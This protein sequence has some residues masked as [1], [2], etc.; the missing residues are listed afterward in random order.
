[1]ARL[2]INM[3]RIK[4]GHI[5]YINSYPIFYTILKERKNLPFDLVSD[6]PTRLNALMRKGDLD[7]SLISS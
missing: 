6:I 7:V 3:N 5:K 4:L 2:K 1:M